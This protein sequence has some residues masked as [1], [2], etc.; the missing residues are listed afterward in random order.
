V[1]VCDGRVLGTFF[2]PESFTDRAD[3]P[4]TTPLTVAVLTELAAIVSAL[5]KSLTVPREER[6][7]TCI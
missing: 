4:S 7:S 2:L 1:Y 6:T 5:Q 3:P